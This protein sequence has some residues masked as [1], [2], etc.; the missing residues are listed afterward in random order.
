MTG[1]LDQTDNKKQKKPQQNKKQTNKK[2]Q[3]AKTKTKTQ[4]TYP[5]ELDKH[6]LGM[7]L[8]ICLLVTSRPSISHISH[9]YF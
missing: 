1:Y 2:Y 4:V 9:R 6:I 3:T 7:N 8:F 5:K